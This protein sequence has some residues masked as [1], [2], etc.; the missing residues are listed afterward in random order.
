MG[1]RFVE[2]ALGR[3]H[4]SDGR[5]DN[6]LALDVDAPAHRLN[7]PFGDRKAQAG[8][9]VVGGADVVPALPEILEDAVDVLGLDPDAVVLDGD[10]RR[11]L[12]RS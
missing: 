6:D 8:A 7:R 9:A 2:R 10:E 5:A 3:Q 1:A 12:A 11:R 4:D